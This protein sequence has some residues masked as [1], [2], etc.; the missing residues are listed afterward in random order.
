M[1]IACHCLVT[2][3]ATFHQRRQQCECT[4]PQGFNCAFMCVVLAVEHKAI[5]SCQGPTRSGTLKPFV[6]PRQFEVNQT[7]SRMTQNTPFCKRIAQILD[8]LPLVVCWTSKEPFFLIANSFTSPSSSFGHIRPG[9]VMYQFPST[10][11]PTGCDHITWQASQPCIAEKLL[12]CKTSL[13]QY[14]INRDSGLVL[15][16]KPLKSTAIIAAHGPHTRFVPARD[17][18]C[19]LAHNMLFLPATCQHTASVP[20]TQ[21]TGCSLLG[22]LARLYS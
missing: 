6:T 4:Q 15:E 17:R 18:R 7:M 19:F 1:F 14:P 21:K 16:F 11:H 3:D 2:P 13:S 5:P 10:N 8:S 22:L 20:S 12:K 9:S